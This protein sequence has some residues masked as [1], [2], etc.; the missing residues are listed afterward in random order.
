MNISRKKL[1][2]FF[3][4]IFGFCISLYLLVDKNYF[5]S[6]NSFYHYKIAQLYSQADF[7]L[8][9]LPSMKGSLFDTHFINQHSFYHIL[10]API[11]AL[12]S[13]FLAGKIMTG[14][15]IGILMTSIQYLFAS[16]KVVMP[17]LFSLVAL[18]ST[19]LGYKR[20]LWERPTALILTM[21]ILYLAFL[22][23]RKKPIY[24]GVL[25]FVAVQFSYVALL[26][27]PLAIIYS[28]VCFSEKK[29]LEKRVMT[30]IWSTVGGMILGLLCS[31]APFDNI[32]YCF[33]L[34]FNNTMTNVSIFEWK[35]PFDI[36]KKYKISVLSLTTGVAFVTLFP[37]K[38]KLEQKVLLLVLL[39]FFIQFL[40]AVRFETYFV[41][42]S[43]I[44][45]FSFIT[46]NNIKTFIPSSFSKRF[47]SLTILFFTL[48]VLVFPVQSL[49]YSK[50]NFQGASRDIYSLSDFYVWY[51]TS[52]Y[53]NEPFLN[54][55][56][57]YWSELFYFDKN[58]KSIPG[59]S[60][61]LFK[62]V[63]SD[64]YSVY[65]HFRYNTKDLTEV[66][67][68]TIQREWQIDLVLAD[69]NSKLVKL[70]K[71][72]HAISKFLSVIKEGD[73]YVFFKLKTP[74]Q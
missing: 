64:K 57:E 37:T 41:I 30:L 4:F 24:I 65:E 35:P 2:R 32:S 17:T 43:F 16:L 13:P 26:L 69:S 68:L 73:N 6:Q 34:I 31:K 15:M 36:I 53:K 28:L 5:L 8:N 52:K 50:Q 74:A 45:M 7:N 38:I 61:F 29:M 47:K 42:F 22:F 59:Y 25:T 21:V 62:K 40:K 66:D 46:K 70:F 48:F 49:W 12:F 39:M 56:W 33:Q 58:N 67:I 55:K 18:F 20:L 19:Y 27:L 10:Y 63:N 71:R 54:Y 44:L 14:L 23:K 60:G 11:V 72:G 3:V 1:S 9:N 51:K